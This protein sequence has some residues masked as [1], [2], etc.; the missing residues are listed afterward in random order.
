MP[1]KSS[2]KQA[3]EN[4]PTEAFGASLGDITEAFEQHR[5][6]HVTDNLMVRL[7]TI[8]LAAIGLIA[9]LAWD[10]VMRDI[11]EY[12][13]PDQTN[14]ALKLLY[15]ILVTILAAVVSVYFKK[16]ARRRQAPKSKKRR[17]KKS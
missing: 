5:L 1:K 7:R 3:S 16:N 17:K 12:L 2:Q 10:D 13:F 11:I 14:L 6:H 9:A 15:A 4:T 8:F